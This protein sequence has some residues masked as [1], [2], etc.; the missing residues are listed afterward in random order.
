MVYSVLLVTF[1]VDHLARLYAVLKSPFIGKLPKWTLI[2]Q[3]FEFE[4]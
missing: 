1:N 4:V 3:E 2:L